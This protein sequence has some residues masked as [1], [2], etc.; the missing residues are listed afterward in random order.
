MSDFFISIIIPTLNE[1]VKLG[2]LLKHLKKNCSEIS[3]EIIIADGGSD[4]GTVQIAESF[5]ATVIHCQK[6]GR[7][8]QM[9]EGAEHSSGTILYFLHA[10]TF[11]PQNFSDYI[12]QSFKKGYKSGCFQLV[13][14]DPDPLLTF[15]GWFTRFRLTLF[16]FGDQS[17]FV[18]KT[19]FEEV[20]GF[21][22][23]MIVMEDQKIVRELKKAGSFQLLDERV[24]T[25]ARRYKVNGVIRLQAVFF[26]ILLLYYSGVSQSTLVHVYKE[27]IDN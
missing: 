6:K 15:Y 21:D 22:E 3:H 19:L 11:P 18:E 5:G 24:T 14:D 9:N 4:D 27:F 23:S 2:G 25:S 20:G 7:A 16:R 12:S 26:L 8:A 1:E 17:L 10:D 13:F